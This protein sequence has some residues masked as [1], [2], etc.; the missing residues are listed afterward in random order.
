MSILVCHNCKQPISAFAKRCNYCD[1][2]V[3]YPE[4]LAS[5]SEDVLPTTHE[6]QRVVYVYPDDERVVRFD[7]NWEEVV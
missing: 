6:E 7:E 1:E 2:A 4:P 3:L 5:T